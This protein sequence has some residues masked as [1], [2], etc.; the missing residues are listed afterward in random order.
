MTKGKEKS[1]FPLHVPLTNSTL[2]FNYRFG[3]KITTAKDTLKNMEG[4]QGL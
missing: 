1:V 3:I 4:V 2:H